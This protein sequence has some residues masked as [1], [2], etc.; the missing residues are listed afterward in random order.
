MKSCPLYLLVV[1]TSNDQVYE[2]NSKII[3]MRVERQENRMCENKNKIMK[4]CRIRQLKIGKICIKYL[5][6]ER[7][8]SLRYQFCFN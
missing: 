4:Q 1:H 3:G 7:K 5:F 6:I 2:E 8:Q